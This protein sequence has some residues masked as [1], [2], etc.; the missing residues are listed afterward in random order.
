MIFT[1]PG[2]P[3]GKHR[4]RACIRHGKIHSYDEQSGEKQSVAW[5]LKTQLKIAQDHPDLFVQA[6]NLVN[7]DAYVV[8]MEFHFS[9][10]SS[11]SSNQRALLLWLGNPNVKPD[12]DNLVKFY[13]DAANK[14]I[15]SDDKKIIE[16]KATKIYSESPRTIIKVTGKKLM[17]TSDKVKGIL[18]MF[19]PSR[20]HEMLRDI[21]FLLRVESIPD[22]NQQ[23]RAYDAAYILSKFADTYS[24]ELRKIKKN[25][26]GYW[27]DCLSKELVEKKENQS[28][29][30]QPKSEVS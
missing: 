6:D 14:V 9:P 3:T 29:K 28:K 12:I 21:G 26:P 25:F 8:E 23:S 30:C 27:Q 11:L 16:V 17:N 13:L 15:W 19:P 22:R 5:R 20:Y 10:P 7:A 24:D 1:I 4:H 18:G 2:I